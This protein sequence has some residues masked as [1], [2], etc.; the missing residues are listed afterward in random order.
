[1]NCERAR[2]EHSLPSRQR[3]E[4]GRN[5]ELSNSFYP[6]PSSHTRVAL[7]I[8]GNKWDQSLNHRR[9]IFVWK[10]TEM[11]SPHVFADTRVLILWTLPNEVYVV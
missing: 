1:M 8:S 3:L 7:I 11:L 5:H 4:M 10:G 2:F 9:L 6:L